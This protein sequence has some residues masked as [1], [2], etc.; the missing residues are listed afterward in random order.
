MLNCVAPPREFSAELNLARM[1]SKI[2][3][4]NFQ[5]L[6]PSPV[7]LISQKTVSSGR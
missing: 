1:A 7:G 3:H 2:M 4:N 6:K 5:Q